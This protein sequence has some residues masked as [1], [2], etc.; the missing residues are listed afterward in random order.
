MDFFSRPWALFPRVVTPS[1]GGLIFGGNVVLTEGVRRA[2]WDAG[3][4]VQS[5]IFGTVN[6]TE[7]ICDPAEFYSRAP[8]R[9]PLTRTRRGLQSEHFALRQETLRGRWILGEF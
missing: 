8:T 9:S 3:Q 7:P 6:P 5:L 2:G 4:H 1:S